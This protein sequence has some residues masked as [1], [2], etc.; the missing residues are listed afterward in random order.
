V[1]DRVDAAVQT[2]KPPRC[3][4]VPD[5]IFTDPS[6]AQLVNRDHPVLSSSEIGNAQVAWGEFPVHITGK[7]PRFPFLP[8]TVA[9]LGGCC[10][11]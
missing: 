11:C 1:S 5:R 9:R 6:P 8:L 10:G 7:S 3:H 4:A 2:M